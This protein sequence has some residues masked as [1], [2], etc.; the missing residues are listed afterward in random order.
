MGAKSLKD[1][2]ATANA[3]IKKINPKVPYYCDMIDDK[4]RLAYDAW[5]ERLYI[6]EKGKIVYKGGPGPFQYDI[7]EVASWL[8]KHVSSK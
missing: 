4:C 5:P 3:W 6:I 7:T 8:H 1:R 2:L